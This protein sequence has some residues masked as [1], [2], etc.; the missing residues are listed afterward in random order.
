MLRSIASGDEILFGEILRTSGGGVQ[1]G[2]GL[3][4]RPSGTRSL[5]V[6]FSL[7]CRPLGQWQLLPALRKLKKSNL[8]VFIMSVFACHS[9]SVAIRGQLRIAGNSLP[10]SD[11]R[12]QGITLRQVAVLG[13]KCFPLLSHLAGWKSNF[14]P[15]FLPLLCPAQVY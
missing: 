13:S 6:P 4:V 1:M 12:A 7:S 3:A 5:L 9:T 14:H 11:L 8:Y 10:S 2:E 15:A